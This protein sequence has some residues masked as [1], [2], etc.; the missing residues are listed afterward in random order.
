LSVR[1]P[2]AACAAEY[3]PVLFLEAATGGRQIGG[4]DQSHRPRLPDIAGAQRREQ[5]RVDLPPPGHSHAAAKFV[6]D[7]HPGDLGWAA[8]TG[9]LSP[10]A[11]LRQQLDQQI[12]GRP[13]RPQ[14]QQR[15]PLK[16]GRTVLLPAPTGVAVRPTFIEEIV[17]HE[18]VPQFQQSRRAGRRKVRIH[19]PSLAQEFQ[20]VSDHAKPR[21]LVVFDC[22][23]DGS[24]HSQH[25]LSGRSQAGRLAPLRGNVRMR[26]A[27]ATGW[28]AL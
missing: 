25:P 7:A 14:P 13:R 28:L 8:Q 22:P 20:L 15:E 24:K 12:H 18:R 10:R 9:K 17:G 21:N 6:P 4:I 2:S 3:G 27:Q 26:P 1:P 11:L 5:M 16:V 23:S 19:G